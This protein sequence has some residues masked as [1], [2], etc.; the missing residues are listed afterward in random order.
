M[1]S[2]LVASPLTVS[3]VPGLWSSNM[4]QS[5]VYCLRDAAMSAS[6]GIPPAWAMSYMRLNPLPPAMF[7]YDMGSLAV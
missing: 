4:T 5:F 7:S 1:K 2:V 3:V 6:T